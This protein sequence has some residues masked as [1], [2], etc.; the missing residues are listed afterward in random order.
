MLASMWA[1]RQGWKHRHVKVLADTT[2][3]RHQ[4]RNALICNERVSKKSPDILVSQ[5]LP[6]V[7]P[8]KLLHAFNIAGAKN[9][10][11]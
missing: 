5:T 2:A 6:C 3:T 10:H 1:G 11:A 4:A 8:S 9:V 7:P